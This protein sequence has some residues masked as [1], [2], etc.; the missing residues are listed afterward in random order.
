MM[1]NL[2]LLEQ[3]R[4]RVSKT[5]N[6]GMHLNVSTEEGNVN[7]KRH[8]ITMFVDINDFNTNERVYT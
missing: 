5:L 4:N 6:E 7:N 2:T 8:L 3:T 1:S